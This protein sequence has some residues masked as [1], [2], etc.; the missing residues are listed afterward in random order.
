MSEAG[1]TKYLPISSA[2]DKHVINTFTMVPQQVDYAK[3]FARGDFPAAPL[4]LPGL[5]C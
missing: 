1:D 3:P 2:K 5:R 4:H